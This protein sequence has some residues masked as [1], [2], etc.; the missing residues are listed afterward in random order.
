MY[1]PKQISYILYNNRSVEGTVQN[2]L[3]D[4]NFDPNRLNEIEKMLSWCNKL[5]SDEQTV[6]VNT[7]ELDMEGS[8]I[9]VSP[10]QIRSCTDPILDAHKYLIEEGDIELQWLKDRGISMDII[11]SKKIG[12]LSY[13]VNKH[14]DLLE[15]LGVSVHPCLE[16]LLDSDLSEG[17]VILTL[18][19]D[20]NILKNCTTRRISDV[21]K[22]KYT[23]AIPDINIWNLPYR[24]E[25]TEC[26][27]SEGIFDSYAIESKLN[28]SDI[29]SLSVSSA[30]WSS[31]QI[32]QILERYDTINIFADNDRVGLRSAAVMKKL[33]MMNGKKC[34]TYISSQAKD[35]AD[36]FFIK[37]LDWNAIQEVKI[38]KDM[39]G[40]APNMVFNFTKYLKD[41]KF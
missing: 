13:I 21:G 41:R 38:T 34:K 31:L 26:W 15:P 33:F 6:E 19:D 40:E 17:G 1:T 2:F 14:T 27:L 4:Y 3:K 8:D 5:Y 20:K 29:D 39:I 11:K 18:F 7:L 36:H 9:V 24:K 10:D 16:T 12:S 28:T 22:L 23:Q 30:M 25:N 37:K 35:P 32:Y